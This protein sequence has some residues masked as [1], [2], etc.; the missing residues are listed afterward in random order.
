[1]QG[2]KNGQEETPKWILYVDGVSNDKRVGT[3]ILIQGSEEQFEYALRFSF[4]ATNNELA[5]TNFDEMRDDVR[6]EVRDKPG[7]KENMIM[8]ILE[9]EE[10]WRSPII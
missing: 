2:P 9:E 7:Y 4:I 1:M 10:D 5:T 8:P 6:I 3:G